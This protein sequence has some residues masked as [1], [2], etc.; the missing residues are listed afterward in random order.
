LMV[1][2]ARKSMEAGNLSPASSPPDGP[3]RSVRM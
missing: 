1:S 3:Y 2:S